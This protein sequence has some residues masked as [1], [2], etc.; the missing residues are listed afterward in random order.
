M[1]VHNLDDVE[2]ESMGEDEEIDPKC[3][4]D[5][6]MLVQPYKPDLSPP[7]SAESHGLNKVEE[8]YIKKINPT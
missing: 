3:G 8:K 5:K 7:T 2:Y 4:L 1:E 6:C